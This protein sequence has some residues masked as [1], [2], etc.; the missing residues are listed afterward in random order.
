MQYASR[1]HHPARHHNNRVTEEKVMGLLGK[2]KPARGGHAPGHL[3][4]GL[5]AWIG[6]GADDELVKVGYDEV[7]IAVGQLLGALWN[8]TDVLPGGVRQDLADL[9]IAAGSVAS[10][11][12]QLKP[13]L[14]RMVESYMR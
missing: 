7:D 14:R 12:R 9:G 6:N 11:V 3:R 2:Y 1:D 13:R 10:A 4:D 8:C 5:Y